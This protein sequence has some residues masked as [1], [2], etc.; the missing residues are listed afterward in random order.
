MP[1]SLIPFEISV[2]TITP[3]L[4]KKYLEDQQINRNVVVSSVERYLA[5]MKA[6]EWVLSPQGIMFDECDQL[7]DGQHRMEALIEYGK[8][9]QMMVF[10]GVTKEIRAHLDRGMTRTIT[11]S[12]Q[13]EGL[14]ITRN[15][16]AVLTAATMSSHKASGN[17]TLRRQSD[18]VIKALAYK[19]IPQ[20]KKAGKR[21]GGSTS[22]ISAGARAAIFRAFVCLPEQ[23]EKIVEFMKILD[24][25]FLLSG[26]E[27]TDELADLSFGVE[28]L[29]K[30]HAANANK[31]GYIA[32][33]ELYLR[34]LASLNAFLSNKAIKKLRPAKSQP[35]PVVDLDAIVSKERK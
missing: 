1:S 14:D 7:I 27:R 28:L 5:S 22:V 10:R 21:Y 29:K 2:E 9:L 20:L 19:Y 15:D 12:M 34:S 17:P 33:N 18:E 24:N 31:S 23:E 16:M 13:I 32:G 6:G 25:G 11:Q 3:E 30:Y 4:A 35:F 26:R 8:P